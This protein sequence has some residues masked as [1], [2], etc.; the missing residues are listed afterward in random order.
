M[1]KKTPAEA[2]ALE[3]WEEAGLTGIAYDHCLG[4]FAYS[5][6]IRKSIVQVV[7]LVYPVQVQTIHSEWPEKSERKRKWFTKEEAAS[8]VN[9][10]ELREII[11]SFDPRHLMR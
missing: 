9:E 7:T 10:P 2:A 5:K 1:P 8:K 3:A 4:V 6:P 11:L